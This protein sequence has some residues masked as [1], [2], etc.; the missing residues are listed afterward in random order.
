MRSLQRTHVFASSAITFQRSSPLSSLGVLASGSDLWVL[1]KWCHAFSMS[2]NK[3]SKYLHFIWFK[4]NDF[5]HGSYWSTF[6]ESSVL[7]KIIL[8]M[9]YILTKSIS[10]LALHEWF[11]PKKLEFQ[12]IEH[13]VIFFR[14]NVTEDGMKALVTLA[15]GDM[16]KALNILQVTFLGK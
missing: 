3:N 16:R 1:T 13:F 9:H 8:Y 10:Y 5:W 2:Y 11:L 14:C 4:A 15:N 6:C 12:I 7:R